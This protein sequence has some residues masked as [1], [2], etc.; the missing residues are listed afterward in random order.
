[1]NGVVL[2]LV[3]TERFRLVIVTLNLQFQPHVV[4]RR[5]VL[6]T[7]EQCGATTE[8]AAGIQ[9]AAGVVVAGTIIKTVAD[10]RQ[11]IAESEAKMQKRAYPSGREI[12]Q[13]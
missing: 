8:I 6:D 10:Q 13:G 7:A 12:S 4:P 11:G 9:R 3:V 2:R 5:L 1:M